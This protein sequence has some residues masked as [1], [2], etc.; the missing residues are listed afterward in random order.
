MSKRDAKFIAG[1]CIFLFGLF[2]GAGEMPDASFGAFLF[3]K[4]AAFAIIFY[5]LHL[6]NKNHY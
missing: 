6:M 2:A 4:I 1:V 3:E 5:G